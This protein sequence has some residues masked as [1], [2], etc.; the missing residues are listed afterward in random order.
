MPA[1]RET[2]RM[3]PFASE[4]VRMSLIAVGL[5]KRSVT[6]AVAVRVVEGLVEGRETMWT[7][8]EG[9]KWVNLGD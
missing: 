8:W 3:S 5:L 1:T 4:A 7:V 2:E 6:W 9:V